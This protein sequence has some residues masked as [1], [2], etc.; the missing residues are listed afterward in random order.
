MQKWKG[1]FKK[2]IVNHNRIDH[3]IYQEKLWK[4]N[5][6]MNKS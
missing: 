6:S 2:Q 5:K 3:K 1:Y 4:I